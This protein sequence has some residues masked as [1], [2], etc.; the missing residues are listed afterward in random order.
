LAFK[1]Y[2]ITMDNAGNNSA[3]YDVLIGDFKRYDHFYFS[4]GE[5]LHV[6]VLLTYLI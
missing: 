1:L 5:F 6:R 2:N 4:S 3:A